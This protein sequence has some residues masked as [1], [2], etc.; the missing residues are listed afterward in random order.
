MASL[1]H[2][3]IERRKDVTI[4]DDRQTEM[5]K[6]KILG[7]FTIHYKPILAHVKN[8]NSFHRTCDVSCENTFFQQS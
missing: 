1:K 8:V 2:H 4:V 6:G 5:S 3:S 7:E